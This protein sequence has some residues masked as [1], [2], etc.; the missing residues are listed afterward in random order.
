MTSPT[1]YSFS[2]E[3]SDTEKKTYHKA[4][5]KTPCHPFE[6][7]AH[8]LARV[9]IFAHAYRPG[10]EFSQGMFEPDDPTLWG[11][12]E[13]GALHTWIQL[14]SPDKKKLQRAMRA[15]EVEIRIYFMNREEISAFCHLLRGSR[16]NWV[17]EIKFFRFQPEFLEE[18]AATLS[19]SS[20][21][22]L[23]F[24]DEILFAGCNGQDFTTT[25]ENVDIWAE[26]Q[27]SLQAER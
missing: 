2:L 21:L 24:S 3:I 11:K 19:T 26:F 12:D 20:E 13:I 27:A 6:S 7:T 15:G 16:T 10:L 22:S 25:I 14:G 4:R 9:I 1:F 23:T 5:T 8:L 17:E 18:A